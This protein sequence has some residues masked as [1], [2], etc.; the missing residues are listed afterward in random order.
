[1]IDSV[2]PEQEPAFFEVGS[3]DG[4]RRIAVRAREGRAPG[5]F[6][7]SGFNSD[8]QGTKAVALDAWAAEHGRACVRFDYSGHGESGGNFTD[9][10]IGRWFE[11][12]LAAF[13]GSEA[14]LVFATGYAANA[15]AITALSGPGALIV[16]DGA[17]HASIVDAC[18]LSRARVV[19]TPHRDTAAVTSALA[20]RDEERALVVTESIFSVDGDDAPLAELAD[21][22]R[23]Y[24][25]VLVVDEAHALGVVGPDGRGLVAECEVGGDPDV[26]RTVTLSKALA[27]QGGAVVGSRALVDH[28]VNVARTFIFD[29]ALAPPAA[30]AALAALRV[31]CA[32]PERTVAAR[33]RAGELARALRVAAPAASVVPVPIGDAERAVRVQQACLE[34]GVL[35]GCFRPPSVPPGTSRLRLT[36]R[37][38][39]QSAELTHATGA[40]LRALAA[41]P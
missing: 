28:L 27:S 33:Q 4:Q 9:G 36:G 1:M 35:V 5:L 7:L 37:A 25:A 17:N 19:V 2:A 39:L 38:T 12:T 41:N 31:L 21:A 22:C 34:Q 11:E 23:S 14:A 16:S 13:T 32:E 40:V 10:T 24:E 20:T 29:T 8:M 6:W 18:R 30:G 3:G 26:V 15:G